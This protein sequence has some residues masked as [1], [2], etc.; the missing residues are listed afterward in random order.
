MKTIKILI[1]TAGVRPTPAVQGGATETMMTH[2]IKV[3]ETEKRA[4][5]LFV[6]A[7]DSEAV[8]A[9][10]RYRHSFFKF[11]R[12]GRLDGIYSFT[13][14]AL[15]KLTKGYIPVKSL[16]IKNVRKI[17]DNYK[18]GIVLVEGNYFQVNQLRE[19]VTGIPLVLHEH[20]D[21]VNTELDL[22]EKIV[23]DCDG[24]I[25]ISEFCRNRVAE[26]DSQC[27]DKVKVLKNTVDINHFVPGDEA[28]RKRIRDKLGVTEDDA[29]ITYCGRLCENK[30]VRNL[31][32]AVSMCEDKHIVLVVIG[33]PAYKGAKDD[34][35]VRNLKEL[36]EKSPS[37]VIF[38]GFIP[39][40]ELPDYY[41]ASDILVVP[42]KCNEAAG[43]VLIEG[44][45][46]GLPIIT[47]TQGGIPEYANRNAALLVD[48]DDKFTES[49]AAAIKKLTKDKALRKNMAR[50]AR[51]YAMPYGIE[52][53]YNNFI[54]TVTS[55]IK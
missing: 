16:Y 12:K 10:K 45:A 41:A 38:T 40:S 5:F 17:I 53:Y 2:L 15:R 52:N 3:N 42:S 23:H 21:G 54:S 28:T 49:L 20:I 4:E 48:V 30:G 55:F 33:T 39:Q 32:E 50:I 43:N 37:R 13:F 6:T 8:A 24:I 46:C 7:Y 14:R 18:P 47:T 51:D 26:V 19:Y 36:S 25:T 9:S 27:H 31:I 11:Y 1:V 34:G 35:F 44:M 22:A 29:V